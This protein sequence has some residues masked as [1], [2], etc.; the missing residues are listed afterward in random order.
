[1]VTLAIDP[2]IQLPEK[3]SNP[4]DGDP[5][6]AWEEIEDPFTKEKFWRKKNFLAFEFQV[7]Y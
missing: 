5:P 3:R 7:T 6:E 2:P 4:A 1:M